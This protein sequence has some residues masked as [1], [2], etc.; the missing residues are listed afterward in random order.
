MVTAHTH[1]T[2]CTLSSAIAAG[3]AIDFVLFLIWLQEKP[4]PSRGQALAGGLTFELRLPAAPVT[5]LEFKL[6]VDHTLA[7]AKSGN[8][9]DGIVKH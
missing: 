1:G 4:Q 3:L 7:L 5:M 8:T 9:L 2:G 6:P